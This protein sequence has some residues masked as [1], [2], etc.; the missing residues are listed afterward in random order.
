[1]VLTIHFDDPSQVFSEP[2]SRQEGRSFEVGTL[3]NARVIIDT[4]FLFNA[5]YM[6]S[7][8]LCGFFVLFFFVLFFVLFC[9]AQM[10]TKILGGSDWYYPG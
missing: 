9:F 5:S 3:W 4:F 1:M 7:P 2:K 6:P 8:V 10:L